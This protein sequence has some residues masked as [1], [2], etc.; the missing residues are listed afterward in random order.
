MKSL[1]YKKHRLNKVLGLL[2]YC[3][4]LGLLC[5]LVVKAPNQTTQ[6]VAVAGGFILGGSKI[7]SKLGFD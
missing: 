6:L 3:F 7:K 4:T 5:F 2:K 1:E